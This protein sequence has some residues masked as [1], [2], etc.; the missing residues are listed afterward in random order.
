MITIYDIAKH[1]GYSPPTVSKALNGATDVSTATKEII[2]TAAREMGYIPNQHAKALVTRKSWLIG[3]MYEE[4][5][6]GIGMEHPLF[7]GI[8]DAFKQKIED[9]GYELLFIARNLGRKKMSYLDHCRY[10]DVDGILILNHAGDNPEVLEVTQSSFLC[11]STNALFPNV[12]TVTSENFDSSIEAVRYLHGLG[13]TKIGHIAGPSN[14]WSDAGL[15]RHEGFKKGLE[16]CGLRYRKD[17]ISQAHLW[18]PDSGY[19]AMRALLNRKELPTALFISGDDLAIG[20][21]RACRESGIDIPQD[22]SIVGFDD[23]EM[24]HL[25]HPRLTT[26]KQDR[27]EIGRRAAELFLQNLEGQAVIERVR[28]PVTLI[29]RESCRSIL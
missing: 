4:T 21:M 1:T 22:I 9:N 27:R 7:S 2:L 10:R 29:E 13:H 14:P 25:I 19:E 28:I 5:D 20:A 6:L 15:E 3:V 26:F 16:L 8:M 23:N 24:A 12:L 17:F 18:H 11:V